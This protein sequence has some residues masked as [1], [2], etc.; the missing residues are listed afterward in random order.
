MMPYSSQSPGSCT[1]AAV[2]LASLPSPWS[3]LMTTS[4][5]QQQLMAS[6]SLIL[7]PTPNCLWERLRTIA[8]LRLSGVPVSTVRFQEA[9]YVLHAFQKKSKKGSATPKQDLDLI[10][11]R[12]A[13]AERLHRERQ[14]EHDH[15]NQKTRQGSKKHRTP[16]TQPRRR[17][18]RERLRRPRPSPASTGT[19]ES[20]A[21]AA[22]LPPY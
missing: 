21:D 19:P 17:D 20:P 3:L 12:L 1:R 11:R 22:H 9:I 15:E 8:G 18:G 13:E 2:P 14:H 4:M 6:R 16:G 10:H 5:R 7:A